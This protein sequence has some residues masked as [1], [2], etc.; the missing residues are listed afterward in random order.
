VYFE[1]GDLD[2][3]PDQ[4]RATLIEGVRNVGSLPAVPRLSAKLASNT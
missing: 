1:G 4:T 2:S 3:L